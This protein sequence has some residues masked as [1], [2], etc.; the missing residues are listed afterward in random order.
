MQ[1]SVMSLVYKHNKIVSKCPH[2]KS[3]NLY[4]DPVY[5]VI[6]CDECKEHWITHNLY[7]DN[8]IKLR[9]INDNTQEKEQ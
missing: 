4:H 7:P 5:D 1:M 3:G 2:C 8:T 6:K 9:E